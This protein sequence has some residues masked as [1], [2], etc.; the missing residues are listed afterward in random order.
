M[1]TDHKTAEDRIP[2]RRAENSRK[3]CAFWLLSAAALGI[4]VATLDTIE[5]LVKLFA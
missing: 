1:Y 2:G 5:Y 3:G 4:T